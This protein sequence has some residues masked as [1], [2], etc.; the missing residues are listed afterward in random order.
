MTEDRPPPYSSEP[1]RSRD[2]PK[3]TIVSEPEFIGTLPVIEVVNEDDDD[4]S[5]VEDSWAA[6]DDMLLLSNNRPYLDDDESF[7]DTNSEPIEGVTEMGVPAE[8]VGVVVQA[9]V[10]S[11]HVSLNAS[12][13]G[14]SKVLPDTFQSNGPLP[15][16]SMQGSTPVVS[17][18]FQQTPPTAPPPYQGQ[19]YPP[20]PG[21]YQAPPPGLYQAPPPAPY[22]VP[23]PGV[24]QAPPMQGYYQAPPRPVQTPPTAPP[25][26]QTLP[27]VNRDVKP[28][29]L[30][31]LGK[32]VY[33]STL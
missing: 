8:V 6:R 23:P 11:D 28:S 13:V 12:D 14:L 17:A 1:E 33:S 18:I 3:S 19:Y 25:T 32:L 2:E 4:D 31:S 10:S 7:D 15:I 30:S 26:Y 20:P 22:Y 29:L 5:M 21:P 24:Y 27:P 9:G 16:A